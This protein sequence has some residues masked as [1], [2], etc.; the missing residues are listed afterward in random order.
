MGFEFYLPSDACSRSF[1]TV[2]VLSL[3]GLLARGI[4]AL[5]G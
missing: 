4:I 5:G 3:G 2:V 1:F